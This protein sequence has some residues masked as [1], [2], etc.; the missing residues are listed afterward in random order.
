VFGRVVSGSKSEMGGA[1]ISKKFLRRG[2]FGFSEV[3][4]RLRVGAINSFSVA[5]MLSVVLARVVSEVVM[6]PQG[7]AVLEPMA[8]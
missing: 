4:E 2:V 8:D 3:V 6:V 1:N 7:R 5:L